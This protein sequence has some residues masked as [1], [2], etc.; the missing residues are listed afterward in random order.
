MQ[1]LLTGVVLS[2]PDRR[3]WREAPRRPDMEKPM[4]Q[5]GEGNV[6]TAVYAGSLGKP[7]DGLYQHR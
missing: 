1:A 4:G 3:S 7:Q 2:S 5:G 6:N